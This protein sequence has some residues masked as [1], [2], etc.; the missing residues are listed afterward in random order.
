M[1]EKTNHE[2]VESSAV[3]DNT[4]EQWARGKL[5]TQQQQLLE[6]EMTTCLGRVRHERR[7]AG[8]PADPPA[9]S[10]N[11]SGKPRRFAMMNGT[12]MVR[13]PRGRDLAERFESKILLLFT[14]WTQEVGTMLPELY[15]HG[16]SS[17]DFDLAL[18]GLLGEGAPLSASSIQRLKARFELEYDAGTRRDLSKLEVVYWRADG[19]YVKAGIADHKSALLTIVGALST[20]EKVV[21]ACESGERESKESWLKVLRALKHRGLTLPRLTGADGHLGIWAALGEL[22]PTGAEQRCWNHKNTNVLDD[23]P[24]HAQPK[25]AEL[26][27]AMPY[28]ETKAGC[29]QRRD[30]FVR[31]YRRTEG[32][33]VDTLLRDW[34]RMVTCYS[35]PQEHWRHL[36]TTN[37]VESPFASVRLRTDASRRYKRV[38]GAKAMIWKMLRVA[39]K[40][41]RRLN[42]PELLPLVA[43]GVMFKDGVMMQS[44]SVKS[45]VN[46]QPERTAA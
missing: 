14:R 46:H 33:A 37:I 19:L 22:H 32:N 18:R 20:G 30:A 25:A 2:A 13:R 39:E 41:W 44:G 11:G 6:E 21:L 24:K 16:L 17:G 10:R 8:S 4:L 42:A 43:S 40:S 31:M 28:V 23:L 45:D 29:E 15:R 26:L 9:G 36:R 5:Q 35:F 27:K 38:E 1:R 12:V 3:C 34:E 7:G